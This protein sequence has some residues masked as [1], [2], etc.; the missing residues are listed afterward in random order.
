MP[1]GRLPPAL[2]RAELLRVK[3]DAGERCTGFLLGDGERIGSS[4]T[5]GLGAQNLATGARG[6]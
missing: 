2:C 1:L 4:Q 3:V 6:A 5:T